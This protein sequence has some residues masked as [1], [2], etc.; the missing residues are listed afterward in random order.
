M[1]IRGSGPQASPRSR[2]RSALARS[3]VTRSARVA[4]PRV[5]SVGQH[6]FTLELGL[7]AMRR[8]DDGAAG[9]VDPQG[10]LL[11]GRQRVAEEL[12]QQLDHVFERMLLIVEDH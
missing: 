6:L 8:Q 10:E 7:L 3:A 2:L 9:V 5:R 4:P 1:L 12:G 11:G